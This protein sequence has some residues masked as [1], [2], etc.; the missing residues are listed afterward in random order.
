MGRCSPRGTC[1]GTGNLGDIS[2]GA[3]ASLPALPVLVQE[4]GEVG[5]RPVG[6]HKTALHSPL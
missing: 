3:S 6:K 1:D 5:E 4:Q 2:L